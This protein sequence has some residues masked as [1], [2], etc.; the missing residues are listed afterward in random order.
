MYLE[1]YFKQE[2]KRW[3]RRRRSHCAIPDVQ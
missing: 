3:S 1:A 2:M